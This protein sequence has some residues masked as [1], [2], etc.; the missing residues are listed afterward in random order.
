MSC[1]SSEALAPPAAPP[2]SAGDE[3]WLVILGV[4]LCELAVGMIALGSNVQRYALTVID[5]ERRSCGCSM[6]TS[7][8]IIG[9][10]TYFAGNVTYTCALAF[11]PASLCAA[12]MAT[13]V[14]ANA[15]ISRALLK[16]RL[17]RC[18]YHG[19]A[20]IM[21]GIAVAA[22]FAPCATPA[23]ARAR[24][25]TSRATLLCRCHRYEPV[26]YTAP[27]LSRLFGDA[28]AS[29]YLACLSLLAAM[30]GGL[31]M[32]YERLLRVEVHLM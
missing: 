21:M 27:D 6:A 7:V 23:R 11:A 8:W 15:G 19:G 32:W 20:L 16:E 2:P 5:R 24:P 3:A 25:C 26:E 12:L 10:L 31:I 17:Q 18:D 1:S 4:L 30:L 29:A 9:L 22:V 13:V 28:G 14:V